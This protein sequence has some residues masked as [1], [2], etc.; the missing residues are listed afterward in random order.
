M[1]NHAFVPRASF[2]VLRLVVGIKLLEPMQL[3]DYLNFLPDDVVVRTPPRCWRLHC[4][5]LSL[6]RREIA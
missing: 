6:Y 3:P 4:K 5:R 1:H 2:G